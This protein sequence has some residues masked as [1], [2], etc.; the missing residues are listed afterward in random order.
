MKTRYRYI[1]FVE[2]EPEPD[3]YWLCMTN[4]SPTDCLGVIEYFKPWKKWQ[5]APKVETA[6]T[7]DC[8]Q[9]IAHFMG[10]LQKPDAETG[11]SL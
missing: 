8:L 6:F 2:P 10:Q 11:V 3:D 9:D 4:S 5:F 7:A 1:H